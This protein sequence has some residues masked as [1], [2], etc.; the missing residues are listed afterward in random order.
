MFRVLGPAQ[1]SL[2]LVPINMT[3]AVAA[4]VGHYRSP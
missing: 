3:P 2:E 4:L 1:G